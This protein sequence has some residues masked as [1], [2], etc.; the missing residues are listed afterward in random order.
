MWGVGRGIDNRKATN[1]KCNP[2]STA[3]LREAYFAAF[4]QVDRVV[5]EIQLAEQPVRR[6]SKGTALLRKHEYAIIA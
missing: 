1:V 4:N 2:A 6:C 5:L 3:V